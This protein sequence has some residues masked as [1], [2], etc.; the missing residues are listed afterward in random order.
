MYSLFKSNSTEINTW[1]ICILHIKKETC[2][3]RESIYTSQ[4]SIIIKQ[5]QQQQRQSSYKGKRLTLGLCYRSFS[6]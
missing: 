1:Y 6:H 3:I 5:Q 2:K 4:L